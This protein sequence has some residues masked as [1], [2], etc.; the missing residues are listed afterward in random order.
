[1]MRGG[2]LWVPP[3]ALSPGVFGD[4]SKLEV[5]NEKGEEKR[6][7]SI[8]T[9]TGTM[10]RNHRLTLLSD[11]TMMSG[12]SRWCPL[13]LLGDTFELEVGNEEG[14]EKKGEINNQFRLDVI[15]VI[16][17]VH[18]IFG[19]KRGGVVLRW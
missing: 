7:R 15:S 6:A 8:I 5:G 10:I 13:L 3:P 18:H 16:W 2:S 12:G 19:K 17:C 9:L 4:E 11:L 14:E 1:M